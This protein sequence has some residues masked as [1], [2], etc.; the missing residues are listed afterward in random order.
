MIISRRE[1]A[2]LAATALSLI[3]V[4][5]AWAATLYFTTSNNF[6]LGITGIQSSQAFFA[7]TPFGLTLANYNQQT[8]TYFNSI[9]TCPA[10]PP[11]AAKVFSGDTFEYSVVIAGD[12]SKVINA[13]ITCTAPAPCTYSYAWQAWSGGPIGNTNAGQ[14]GAVSGSWSYIVYMFAVISSTSN[15]GTFTVTA[16]IYG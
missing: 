5:A 2:V 13:S 9:W 4:G 3:I 7:Y 14:I 11:G 12:T 1:K 16:N 15:S 8:C 10:N 6:T